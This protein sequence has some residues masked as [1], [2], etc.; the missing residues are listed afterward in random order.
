MGRRLDGAPPNVRR[1]SGHGMRVNPLLPWTDAAALEHRAHRRFGV[2]AVGHASDEQGFLTLR[3]MS[4]KPINRF[5]EGEAGPLAFLADTAGQR[6]LT[7]RPPSDLV[8]STAP[9]PHQPT[10]P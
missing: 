7:P 3:S 9:S 5:G 2:H 1:M 8:P 4:H 6:I 10:L